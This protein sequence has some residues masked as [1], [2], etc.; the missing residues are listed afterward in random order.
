MRRT[1]GIIIALIFV[2]ALFGCVQTP[3]I[4]Q[5]INLEKNI[6]VSNMPS[7]D[8][9]PLED[10]NWWEF[11]DSINDIWKITSFSEGEDFKLD[12]V[13]N[14][15]IIDRMIIKKEGGNY[16][17]TGDGY[18]ST[19]SEPILI[20]KDSVKAGDRW[21]VETEMIDSTLKSRDIRIPEKWEISINGPEKVKTP[22]GTKI[23]YM[24]F[25]QISKDGEPNK[26]MTWYLEPGSG[27]C[28]TIEELLT[29]NVIDISVLTKTNVKQT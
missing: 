17:V 10:G 8:I 4:V 12:W 5:Q 6:N 15:E 22:A 14:E 9:L 20:L 24:F 13:F 18:G 2:F 23:C 7:G 25:Y 27:F 1:L 19:Y 29:F 11:K 21:T 28:K 3:N 16:Y 26:K